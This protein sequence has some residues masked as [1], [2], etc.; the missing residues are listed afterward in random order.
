[1]R[2]KLVILDEPTSLLDPMTASEL[3]S[4]VDRIRKETSATFLVVEHRLDLLVRIADKLIVMSEG[5]KVMDG[6]PNDVL[7]DPDAQGYGVAV[8]ALTKLENAMIK[9]GVRLR[10]NLLTPEELAREVNS[11]AR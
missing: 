4:T 9:D 7:S 11:K 1:M 10:G 3:V 6:R 2:P 8:P 5:K